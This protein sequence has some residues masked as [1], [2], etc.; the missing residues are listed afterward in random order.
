MKKILTIVAL[1]ST[2]CA[3]ETPDFDEITA[4]DIPKILSIIKEGTKDNLPIVLDDYTTV[5]DVV[6][7]ENLIEY[8]NLINTSNPNVKML[9][10]ADKGALAKTT[11]ENNRNYLCSDEETRLLLK[12]GAVFSYVFYDFTNIELFKFSVQYKDCY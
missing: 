1:I 11:F 9:L 6:S 2:L 7:V 5:F 10:K 3:N 12:K 8:K 4:D